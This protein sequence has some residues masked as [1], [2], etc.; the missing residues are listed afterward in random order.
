[1]SRPVIIRKGRDSVKNVKDKTSKTMMFGNDYHICLRSLEIP[2]FTLSSEEPGG[3]VTYNNKLFGIVVVPQS[4][5]GD[6]SVRIM[7]VP[8]MSGLH[9][10]EGSYSRTNSANETSIC[11][12][13]LYKPNLKAYS[14]NQE[15]YNI[16]NQHFDD[17]YNHY[18]EIATSSNF[19][20][21]F[22]AHKVWIEL[23]DEIGNFQNWRTAAEYL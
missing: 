4:I 14:F 2:A 7:A 1:M 15:K 16:L 18:N 12:G 11:T 23:G 21:G 10:T 8:S 17:C 5:T 13:F 20:D 3:I 6:N 9:P 19:Y 22:D